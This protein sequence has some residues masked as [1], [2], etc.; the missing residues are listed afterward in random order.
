MSFLALG[1]VFGD[2]GTSPLYAMRESLAS[3]GHLPTAANVLG[4]LSLILW[5]L[6]LVVCFK[7]LIF[8]LRAE[9]RGDG[10]IIAL[11]ALLRNAGRTESERAPAGRRRL[12]RSGLVVMA[13]G[14]FGAALLY[15]DGM[16]TPTIT[17]LSAVE[18]L[19]LAVPGIDQLIL[20]IV[21]VILFMLFW[22]Q[23]RG[24]EGVARWFAPVM[25]VW[26]LVLAGLGFSSFIQTPWVA[27]AFNPYYAVQF[28]VYN[29]ELGFV[30]LGSVFLCVTGAEVLY[31]SLGHF[32]DKPIRLGWF[33]LIFPALVLNY[34]GQAAMAIR[35]PEAAHDIFFA[36][37]PDF[38]ASISLYILVGLATAAAVIASQAVISGAFSLMSQAIALNVSPRVKIVRTSSTERGQIYIP[39]LNFVL[40]T[41][42]IVLAVGF[43]TSSNLAGAYGVAISSD[44]LITTCLMFLVMR[45][46]WRWPLYAAL[47]LTLVFLAMDI[48]FWGANILKI[49]DGGWVPLVVA[50][51][52][53]LVM[54]VWAKNRERLISALQKRTEPLEIFLDRLSHN[55]PHRVSGTAVFLT[56]P[57]LGVPPMLDFH[58]RHNQTLHEHVLLLSVITTDKPLEKSSDRIEV[59]PYGFGFYRVNLFY[60]FKQAQPVMRSLE[61]AA[62]RGLVPIDRER[63]TF[64]F[65]RE[66]IVPS[67]YGG[68]LLGLR[69]RLAAYWR[70]RRG[71]PE[72][73][74]ESPKRVGLRQALSE[75]LFVI[76][77]RNALRAT[78]FFSIPDDFTV[79]IGL[80]L[81]TTSLSEPDSSAGKSP[82]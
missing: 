33:V 61:K 17:V 81:H 78:D 75:R 15:G 46:L 51:F 79:E 2:I 59:V 43:Q 3:L 14:T 56:S 54:R 58:L 55:M 26:F 52:A 23:R 10:G 28:F 7:Y 69:R 11:M 30:V 82:R 8:V 42:C 1:V 77:H 22:F 16:I 6:I 29:K 71:K 67:P 66:T 12:W 5:A 41:A 47:G 62:N 70:R 65:G 39:S 31:A 20:P 50:L 72:A 36:L 64:Y 74:P 44:M 38:G 48:P 24:T 27:V 32:G 35:N 73:G 60:G 76:M 34:L 4:V 37:A 68:P 19:E 13:V 57:G 21:C 25:T 40:M 45:W 80:R 63:T 18:G 9:N 53:F 49:T